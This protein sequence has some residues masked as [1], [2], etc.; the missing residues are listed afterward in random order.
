MAKKLGL[1]EKLKATPV[2]RRRGTT[3]WHED[4]PEE[5]QVELNQL[6]EEYQAGAYKHSKT[7]VYEV[8]KQELHLEV[9]RQAFVRWLDEKPNG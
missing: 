7:E 6:R 3:P 2:R 8:C 5:T 9:K 1:L 4:L